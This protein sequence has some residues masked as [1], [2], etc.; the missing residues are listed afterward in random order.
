M[1]IETDDFKAFS[2]HASRHAGSIGGPS[3]TR[4][5]PLLLFAFGLAY[6]TLIVYSKRL[7]GFQVHIPTMVLTWAMMIA[8]VSGLTPFLR[9]RMFPVDGGLT[10]GPKQVSITEEGLR[11]ISPHHE[12]IYRWSV[13][14]AVADTPKHIFILLDRAAGVIVP[15]TSFATPEDCKNF[16]A[17]V[18]QKAHGQK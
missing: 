16:L 14:Q 8:V 17:A 6:G 4:F 12:A 5:V 10:L 15:K 18:R 7:L 9:R 13:V 2:T 3:V 1:N 11:E